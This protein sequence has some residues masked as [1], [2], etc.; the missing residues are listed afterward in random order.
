MGQN[1]TNCK[2]Y[3]FWKGCSDILIQFLINLT[4]IKKNL[5]SFYK[6]KIRQF[7]QNFE[8]CDSEYS[9]WRFEESVRMWEVITQKE[10]ILN[11]LQTLKKTWAGLDWFF[12]LIYLFIILP[13]DIIWQIIGCCFFFF[14]NHTWA[15]GRG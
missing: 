7:L 3:I 11:K 14:F 4:E 1:F 5:V 2:K 13:L 15:L 8:K 9:F 6:I 10:Y 12:F